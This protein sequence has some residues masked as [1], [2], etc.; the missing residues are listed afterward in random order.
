MDKVLVDRNGK[1]FPKNV[2]FRFTGSVV[3]QPAPS[4]KDKVY[5]ADLSG[6]LITIFPVTNHTVMQTS[7]T[8]GPNPFLKL[9]TNTKV[10][11]KE[12]HTG[13]TDTGSSAIDDEINS[14]I[15]YRKTKQIRNPKKKT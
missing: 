6:T 1:P 5:G 7:L 12:R 4:K 9:E 8:I 13:Q 2:K 10:L 11:P 15:E 3:R 14:K